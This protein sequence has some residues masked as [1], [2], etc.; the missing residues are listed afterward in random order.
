MERRAILCYD[1]LGECYLMLRRAQRVLSR[2]TACL[3]V[4]YCVTACSVNAVLRSSM[5]SECCLARDVLGKCYIA[6]RRAR[7]VLSY[8]TTCS[9]SD[10]KCYSALNEC[11]LTLREPAVVVV[12]GW[13]PAVVVDDGWEPTVV[14]V[15][16]WE[17]TVVVV[18]G[19]EP[20][21]VVVDG[22]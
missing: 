1:V 2:D 3:G 6:L 22:W 14:V 16:G 20:A 5:L 7:Q 15:E 19:R 17:P 12:D 10:I 21:V 9:A 18:D 8:V 4:Q 11:S 13:E